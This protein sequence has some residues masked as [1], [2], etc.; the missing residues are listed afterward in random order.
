M[1]KSDDY[2][3]FDP[4]NEDPE[5]IAKFSERMISQIDSD[6]RN[7]PRVRPI[8][9]KETQVFY[10]EDLI[11]GQK[12]I[13]HHTHVN[14]H[15]DFRFKE[16]VYEDGVPVKARFIASRGLTDEPYLNDM[17]ITPYSEYGTWSDTNWTE[18]AEGGGHE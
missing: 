16:L 14:L 10:P 12:Y 11:P 15:T 1:L 9:N 13:R 18:K 3:D 7:M 5:Y 4:F 2:N 8:W 6:M 17:G